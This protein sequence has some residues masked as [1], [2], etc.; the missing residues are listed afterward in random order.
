[1]LFF[2][3]E[4]LGTTLSQF[5]LALN[6]HNTAPAALERMLRRKASYLVAVDNGAITFR[7]V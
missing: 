7:V 4:V 6:S 2:K 1:M 5:T 3:T